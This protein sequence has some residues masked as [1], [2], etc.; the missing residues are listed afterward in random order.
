MQP[1]LRVDCF[2]AR[3][4]HRASAVSRV[5]VAT[6]KPRA[7][8][9]RALQ[10]E[11]AASRVSKQTKGVRFETAAEGRTAQEEGDVE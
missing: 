11:A 9:V 5:R 10:K 4:R 8:R 3:G 6:R 1:R 2:A 7:I